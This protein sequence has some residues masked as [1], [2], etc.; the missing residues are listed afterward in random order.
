MNTLQEKYADRIET[1]L[2]KYPDKRS[3]VM[4]LLYIAQEEYGW[5]SPEGIQDVA[6]VC[7]MDPTQVKSIAGFYTMYSERPKGRF[8]LQVCTDLPCALKGAEK[9]HHDLKEY[10]GVDEGGTSEDG[11]FTVEHVMCLAACDKAPLLQCN[12]HNYEHL[13]M[14]KMKVLLDQW[15]AEVNAQVNKS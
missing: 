10:L 4:A 5:V 6:E 11:M 13:D 9:F 12:F 8:W 7:D 2:A 14:E 3:A 15:R 1:T